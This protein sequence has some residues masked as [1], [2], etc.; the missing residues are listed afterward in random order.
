LRALMTFAGCAGSADRI[1]ADVLRAEGGTAWA[2][3]AA[4]DDAPLFPPID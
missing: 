2:A 3:A 4:A 1:A